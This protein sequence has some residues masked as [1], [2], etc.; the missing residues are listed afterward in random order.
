[1]ALWINHT[2]NPFS[3]DRDLE[4]IEK[5]NI[6]LEYRYAEGNP[7]RL[8]ALAADLVRLPVDVIVTTTDQGARSA[9]Q[10]TP[11][12]PIVLTTGDPVGSGLAATLAKPGGNVTGLTVLLADLT[13]KRLELLKETI[14]RLTRLA[15]LWSADSAGI[16]AFKETQAAAL[17]FSLQLTL[18]R[19]IASKKLTAHF[20]RCRMRARKRCTS[21]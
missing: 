19:S 6:V 5:K 4:Y 17:G 1:M 18:L 16:S 14:P 3:K 15:L 9:S 10:A 11:T 2:D 8:A 21:Y 12:I 7:D 13:G 20:Q